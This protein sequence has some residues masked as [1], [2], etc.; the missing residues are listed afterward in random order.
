M[1]T[2]ERIRLTY[3]ARQADRGHYLLLRAAEFDYTP[4]DADEVAA[5][6]RQLQHLLVNLEE[7]CH[8]AA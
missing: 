8:E 7:V 6:L 4:I 5:L 1:V 2:P 3:M